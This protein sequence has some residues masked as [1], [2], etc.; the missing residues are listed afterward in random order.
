MAP[1]RSLEG[2]A[3]RSNFLRFLP[4]LAVCPNGL[5]LLISKRPSRHLFRALTRPPNAPRWR[6]APDFDFPILQDTAIVKCLAVFLKSRPYRGRP[7]RRL[8][9]IRYASRQG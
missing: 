7:R 3:G 5:S 9:S 1:F 8:R 4:E 6:R 2:L